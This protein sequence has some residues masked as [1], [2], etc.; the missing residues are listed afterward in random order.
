M[1]RKTTICPN[2]QLMEQMVLGLSTRDTAV[3]LSKEPRLLQ[4]LNKAK[5][6]RT[7]LPRI[8]HWDVSNDYKKIQCLISLITRIIQVIIHLDLLQK[9]KCTQTCCFH[10]KPEM[11]L[12]QEKVQIERYHWKADQKAEQASPKF[13]PIWTISV[14]ILTLHYSIGR[15]RA[16][17]KQCSIMTS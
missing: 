6:E 4:D 16:V 14:K 8:L 10:R 7:T 12:W 9:G 15:T 2:L 17:T 13:P 3:K 11:I 5:M 1:T